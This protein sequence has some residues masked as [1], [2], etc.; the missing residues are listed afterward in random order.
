MNRPL[1]WSEGT[2]EREILDYLRRLTTSPGSRLTGVM[3]LST[4]CVLD[5]MIR[6]W[7]DSYQGGQYGLIVNDE[8]LIGGRNYL[9]MLVGST[10]L[11]DCIVVLRQIGCRWEVLAHFTDPRTTK[12]I[13][14]EL[15]K[16]SSTML[17]TVEKLRED[18]EK[19]PSPAPASLT[20]TMEVLLAALKLAAV[21]E[22]KKTTA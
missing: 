3:E 19:L 4:I 9:H 1:D 21:A 7:N 14:D 10:K 8:L 12:I 20:A 2:P 18:L 6:I 16:H 11:P 22:D 15:Q 5:S 17:R 13:I